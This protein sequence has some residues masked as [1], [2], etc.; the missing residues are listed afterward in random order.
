MKNIKKLSFAI[1]TAFVLVGSF[2]MYK[3]ALAVRGEGTATIAKD[4]S[5][6]GGGVTVVQ[7]TSH[8]YT[9]VLTVG[10]SGITAN[11]E[12][13]TFTI[14]TGFTTPDA[15]YVANAEL[16]VAD[17]NWSVI[18]GGTC[19]VESPVAGLTKAVGQV[20]TVDVSTMCTVDPV[21]GIITLTYKGTSATVG[22]TSVDVGVNDVIS[23]TPVKSIS[24]APNNATLPTITVTAAS[25]TLIVKKV[26]NNDNGGTLAV[27]DFSFS[28]NGDPTQSFEVDGQ[29]DLSVDAGTYNIT[30][31]A[32]AGYTTSYDNCSDL[33]IPGGGSETCTITNDDTAQAVSDDDEEDDT[34]QAV[35][36]DDEEDEN[37]EDKDVAIKVTKKANP[38]SLSGPGT[39]IYTY[40]VTN[41][42]NVALKN[43]SVK[44][45]KCSP[46]KYVSGDS[47]HNSKLG[48]KEVWKYTCTKTVST[49][50]T[51]R[52]TARGT[53]GLTVFD[54]AKST[55]AVS[56]VPGFPNTGIG[57]D[58]KSSVPWNI[59]ISIGI[60]IASF[61]FYS[62]L[63]RKKLAI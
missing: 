53:N 12:N 6:Q 8:T 17:G 59:I 18:G 31:P 45:D 38:S 10:A 42:G 34:A 26:V 25:A 2:G 47:N 23:S 15:T 57:P 51:N 24:L 60:F 48:V 29:N 43:V 4:G 44:D 20:I 16:V 61:L 54:H 30:E 28:V 22:V 46:V 36:D 39:V 32:T 40:K 35:S 13:P 9:V 52:A 5:T 33:D 62:Y 37:N 63:A 27:E 3:I 49:T 58:D 21:E 14:P 19:L 56:A 50:E 7:S 41:E 11:A 1:I 55:V